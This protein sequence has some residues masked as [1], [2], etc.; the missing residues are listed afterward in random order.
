MNKI[1]FYLERLLRTICVFVS[2]ILMEAREDRQSF[3]RNPVV[4]Q[5]R[6]DQSY[7]GEGSI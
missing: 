6:S 5:T 1:R 3:I 4:L 7:T 2:H